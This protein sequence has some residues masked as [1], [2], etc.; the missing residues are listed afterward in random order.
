MKGK[1][2]FKAEGTFWG[3]LSYEI[4]SKKSEFEYHR[5][6]VGLFGPNKG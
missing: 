4:A 6:F 3:Y 1:K 2:L 5:I